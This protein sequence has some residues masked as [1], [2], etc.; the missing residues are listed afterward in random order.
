MILASVASFAHRLHTLE[1][2]HY[3]LQTDAE[4]P[5][6]KTEDGGTCC[7]E[8]GA[9]EADPPE[10]GPGKHGSVEVEMTVI[11]M[12]IEAAKQSWAP[13]LEDADDPTTCREKSDAPERTHK[14][15]LR[16]SHNAC[17]TDGCADHERREPEV[18]HTIPDIGA[19]SFR[20]CALI[21][22]KQVR[23]VGDAAREHDARESKEDATRHHERKLLASTRTAAKLVRSPRHNADHERTRRPRQ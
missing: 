19:R 13:E 10:R 12:S 3:M 11:L 5:I 22:V 23:K 18:P 2:S 14:L 6:H 15:I 20:V 9:D 8:D 21:R 16:C 4:G 1:S 7:E 17:E